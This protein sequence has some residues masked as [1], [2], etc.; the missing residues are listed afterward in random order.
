MTTG[1]LDP[2][3]KSHLPD[4]NSAAAVP[5]LSGKVDLRR[6]TWGI[7]HVR[8]ASHLDAFAGLGFA[9]A[10][11]RLWQMEALLRRG[12]GRY[13]QWVGKSALSPAMCWPGN[14]TPRGA[15]RRDFALLDND[16]KAMLEAYA[17]GV[18][19]FIGLGT[20]P[21]GIRDSRLR[22]R[23][24]GAVA[25]DRGDAPDRIPDGLGMVEA[26]ARGGAADRR[27]RQ[28]SQSCVSTMAAT[29][30][31]AFRPAPKASAR[32]RRSPISS[33]VSQRCWRPRR[34]RRTPKSPAAATIGRSRP[35][36]TATG[37]PIARR[38]SASR[39]GNAEHV[40]AG[41]SRLRRVRRHRPHRPRRARF[42]AFRP[43]GKVAWCVTHAFVDIH[44]LY[45]EQ[46]D[47]GA[48][49]LSLQGGCCRSTHRAETI[50]VRDGNDVTIDVVE[51]QHGPV[52]AGDPAEGHRLALRSVQFAVPDTSFDCMLPD[53]ARQI[54]RAIIR[55]DA[56][57]GR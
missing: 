26:V 21:V 27:R 24:M 50:K 31:C 11:D 9:H 38:R 41:A 49:P 55:G 35:E 32:S 13:A 3:S 15:S 5:G 20:W 25:F 45:V 7:P 4:F 19:A 28:I 46:F 16:T 23:G 14:S 36:R 34:T 53:A 44:D 12:T 40:R 48:P 57:L 43:N 22:G 37:R 29:T 6:D 17:R 51:T 30:C 54:G 47:A 42:S 1:T 8:A 52:I 18:N 33:P 56:R 2:A 10:Q 39:V